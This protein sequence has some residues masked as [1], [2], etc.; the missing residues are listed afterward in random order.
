MKHDCLHCPV[1]DEDDE[2]PPTA[3]ELEGLGE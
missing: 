3:E 1:F 2:D